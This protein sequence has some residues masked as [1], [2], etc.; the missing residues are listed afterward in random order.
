MKFA[1]DAKPINSIMEANI[2]FLQS[3]T[4]DPEDIFKFAVSFFAKATPGVCLHR[5]KLLLS[6]A[7]TAINSNSPAAQE[8]LARMTLLR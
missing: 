7:I 5:M 6:R 3:T 1:A 8:L 2:K 4:T